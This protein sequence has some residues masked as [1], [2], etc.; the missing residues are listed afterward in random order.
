MAFDG[1]PSAFHFIQF[2]FVWLHVPSTYVSYSD[3][4]DLLFICN[5]QFVWELSAG[6]NHCSTGIKQG[7]ARVWIVWAESDFYTW[8]IEIKFDVAYTLCY[9]CCTC[10]WAI[11]QNEAC[12]A[13]NIISRGLCSLGLVFY[14]FLIDSVTSS[15][16]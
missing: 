3:L 13:L 6:V 2:F 15:I 16:T 10:L 14:D 9:V 4:T 7:E 12:L 5:I 1:C 8:L 11:L